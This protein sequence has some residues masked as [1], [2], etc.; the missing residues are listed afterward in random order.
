MPMLLLYCFCTCQCKS[1]TVIDSQE[2]L[3]SSTA[4]T[5]PPVGSINLHNVMLH[6][7]WMAGGQMHFVA[8]VATLFQH[9][10]HSQ[11]NNH[12]QINHVY[13]YGKLLF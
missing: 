12:V 1:V 5:I 11:R 2:L 13:L 8:S 9:I 3:P 4:I 7:R 6:T 10:A